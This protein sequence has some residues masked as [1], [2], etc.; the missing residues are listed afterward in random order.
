MNYK[1][2]KLV[3]WDLDETLWQGVLSDGNVDM[4]QS[5]IQLIKDM[6]NN[7]V[8]C[9]I[10]SKNDERTVKEKLE[11]KGIADLFVFISINWSPKGERVRQIVT[12]MQLRFPNVLFID[13]NPLNRAEVLDYCSGISVSDVDI[14]PGLIDYYQNNCSADLEHKR[15]YQYRILEEKRSFKAAYAS[16][17]DFLFASG[18][19]VSIEHDCDNHIDRIEE[20]ILRSNQ[21]NFTKIRSKRNELLE[22]LY[23]KKYDLG[24]VRTKDKFG[25]YGIVGF[26]ALKENRL[27]HFVFSCRTLGMGVE[28][29]VYRQLGCPQIQIEGEVSSNLFEVDPK[30]INQNNVYVKEQKAVTRSKILIKGPCD[31]SQMFAYI[32]AGD[33]II[34]EFV[35]VNDNGVRIEQGN[36]TTM[37]VQSVVLDKKTKDK[38]IRKYPFSDINMFETRL[39]DKDIDYAVL[40]LF[41]DPNLGVYL[42]NETGALLPFGEY[43]NDLT[44]EKNWELFINKKLFVSGC[45]FSAESLSMIKTN[46]KF[47]GRLSPREIYEN[48]RTIFERMSSRAHLI[49]VLGSETPFKG[50]QQPAYN[51]RDLFHREL[52]TLIRNFANHNERIGIID[53]N[54]YITGQES[55][56][57]NINHFKREIYYKMS[58]D[59][60]EIIN[61]SGGNGLREL[62]EFGALKKKVTRKLRRIMKLDN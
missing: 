57:D 45:T 39:F 48:V 27:I 60:V 11:E 53:V 17:E 38:I 22:M 61:S 3:I 56:V 24:Y 21:L 6:V 8:M 16:N 32:A 1:D 25:D 37:I 42:D 29:Y 26:Y 7:G 36:H 23:D 59:L 52:N 14:I 50:N 10:C 34:T 43:T 2:I 55:F 44:D 28:Q 51:D 47:I 33:N 58:A 18:I 20:L 41:T 49:L 35:Y 46:L 31:M 12:E 54:N 40:S 9:S 4:P 30:W 13:D 15:L 19:Q 62:T 5:H